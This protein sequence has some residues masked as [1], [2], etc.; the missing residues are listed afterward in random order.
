MPVEVSPP[1]AEALA[2]LVTAMATALGAAFQP[3][4]VRGRSSL[5]A[6]A[7]GEMSLADF[8]KGPR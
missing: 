6:L 2:A 1:T 8:E 4:G 7:A 5:L 3:V